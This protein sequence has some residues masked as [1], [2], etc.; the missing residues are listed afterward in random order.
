M[1]IAQS[2]AET[3]DDFGPGLPLEQELVE[4]GGGIF[5]A[6]WMSASYEATPWAMWRFP[7]K[8]V[9][10]VKGSGRFGSCKV[11]EGY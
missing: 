11:L 2:F 3:K 1:T 6:S 10:F 9:L 7:D 4:A 8:S 5:N